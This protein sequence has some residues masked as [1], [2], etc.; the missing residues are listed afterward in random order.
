MSQDILIKAIAKTISKEFPNR[1]VSISKDFNIHSTGVEDD[2]YS[3]YMD[4]LPTKTFD[5]LH[6]LVMY[7][8]KITG[9]ERRY[10]H[11][12]NKS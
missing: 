7:A 6:D 10:I 3:L 8:E 2:Y 1:F 12:R 5:N 9:I 4:G 11:V